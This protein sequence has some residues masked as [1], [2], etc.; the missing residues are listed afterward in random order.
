MDLAIAS[1]RLLEIT[2]LIVAIEVKQDW[3][4]LL[5]DKF[6][7]ALDPNKSYNPAYASGSNSK[8]ALDERHV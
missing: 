3:R 8:P 5:R 4:S 6:Q 2:H 1:N 7:E